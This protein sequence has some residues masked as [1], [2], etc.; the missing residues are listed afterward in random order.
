MKLFHEYSH[1][2]SI[3]MKLA[4]YHK[5]KKLRYIKGTKSCNSGIVGCWQYSE[6]NCYQ[7]GMLSVYC[8]K[9]KKLNLFNYGS[10]IN[11]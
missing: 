8:L 2:Q 11:S 7:S 9:D 1:C 4:W 3:G 5:W 10:Q 6:E